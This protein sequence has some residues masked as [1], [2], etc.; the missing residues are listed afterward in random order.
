M[1]ETLCTDENLGNVIVGND[2]KMKV[3]EVGTVCLKLQD[4]TIKKALNVRYVPDASKNVLSLSVLASRGYRFV[5][6]GRSCKVY[7][8]R[9]LILQE[10]MYK[11][12]IYCLDGE[13]TTMKTEKGEILGIG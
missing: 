12:N 1:F 2:E 6:R 11:K 5:G 3:Q 7:K 8:G 13:A 4:G 9:N 10:M